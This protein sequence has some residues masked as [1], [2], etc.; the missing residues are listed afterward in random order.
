MDSCLD[1]VTAGCRA[2]DERIDAIC[3]GPSQ[4][5]RYWDFEP[6]NE[7]A[8]LRAWRSYALK[9]HAFGYFIN[10]LVEAVN[11]VSVGSNKALWFPGQGKDSFCDGQRFASWKKDDESH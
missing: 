6:P 9:D 7:G 8:F 10:N 2:Y 5:V 3:L 11:P 1:A 4:Y